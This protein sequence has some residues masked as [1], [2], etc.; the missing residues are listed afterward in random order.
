MGNRIGFVPSLL[1]CV[2]KVTI[3]NGIVGGV[4]TMKLSEVKFL[5]VLKTNPGESICHGCFH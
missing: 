1:V 4:L 3:T 2:P 5:D